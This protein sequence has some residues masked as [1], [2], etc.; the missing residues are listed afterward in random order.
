MTPNQEWFQHVI[1]HREV[2]GDLDK[3][4]NDDWIHTI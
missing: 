1:C 4:F 2:G 3:L